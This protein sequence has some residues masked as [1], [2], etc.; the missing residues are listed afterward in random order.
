MTFRVLT[1]LLVVVLGMTPTGAAPQTTG[2]LATLRIPSNPAGNASVVLSAPLP[3]L[4]DGRFATVTPTSGYLFVN[5]QFQPWGTRLSWEQGEI[6]ANGQPIGIDDEW[7][8]TATVTATGATAQ[9]NPG[10]G[11][12]R[13]LVTFSRITAALENGGVVA[14]F[15]DQPPLFADISNV[16]GEIL[17]SFIESP[18]VPRDVRQLKLDESFRGDADVCMSWLAWFRPPPALIARAEMDVARMD[19][20]EK[21]NKQSAVA[22]ERL[23]RWRYPFTITGMVLVVLAFGSLLSRRPSDIPDDAGTDALSRIMLQST[24][25]IVAMSGLDLGWTLLAH[26]ANAIH[27]VNPVGMQFIGNPTHLA[28]FKVS[29]TGLGLA[30]LYVLR[31]HTIARKAIW[32]MCL[33][34]ALLTARWL[35]V[36][37]ANV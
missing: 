7:Q 31:H 3:E 8:Q 12:A 1:M 34:L 26:Q 36:A 35:L 10:A 18:D 32:W 6:S 30:I 14:L 2:S 27:E 13:S 9:A 15:S 28:I 21:I 11:H 37:G 16:G 29:L 33:V 23:N 19:A 25:L 22:A 24:A 4:E 5:G 17:R 20:T